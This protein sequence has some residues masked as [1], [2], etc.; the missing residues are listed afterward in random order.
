MTNIKNKNCGLCYKN[1]TEYKMLNEIEIDDINNDI[2]IYCF[3]NVKKLLDIIQ[4]E[5]LHS[6][7]Y[8][9]NDNNL[10]CIH[11]IINYFD[12]Y[13]NHTFTDNNFNLIYN[14]FMPK[15]TNEIISQFTSLP[16]RD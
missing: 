16:Y 13:K 8:L 14:K 6:K 1:S 15:L 7:E 12:Y 3:D 4:Y 11:C 5:Y 2:K 9:I 10:Y